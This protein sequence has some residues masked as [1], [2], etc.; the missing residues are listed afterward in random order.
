MPEG[1]SGPAPEIPMS[2]AP[3]PQSAL[4]KPTV[5][6]AIA[7]LSKFP[8][9]TFIYLDDGIFDFHLLKPE[10]VSV[11]NDSKGSIIVIRHNFD[12]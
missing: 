12:D 5:A 10:N 6:N 9:D 2:N 4:S 3:A 7:F 8:G 1:P 11:L